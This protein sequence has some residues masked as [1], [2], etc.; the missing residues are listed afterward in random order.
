[1]MV[2]PGGQES[3]LVAVA[4]PGLEAGHVTVERDRAL[5]VAHLQVDV[6]DVDSRVDRHQPATLPGRARCRPAPTR[7]TPPRD[8][9]SRPSGRR[10]GARPRTRWPCRRT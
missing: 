3:G 8:R 7:S 10:A 6:P 2:A 1:M 4:M 5:E 9:R